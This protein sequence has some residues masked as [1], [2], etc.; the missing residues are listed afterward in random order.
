[1][2]ILVACRSGNVGKSTLARHLLA[3]R[4]G[5]AQVLPV[6]SI[7]SD[8]SDAEAIRGKQF[9]QVQELLLSV[10]SAII[11][12][13]SSNYEDFFDLMKTYA[14]SHED[15]DLFVI[16]TEPDIK[17]ERDTVNTI[18]QLAALGVPAH[19]IVVVFNKVEKPED[20]EN[21]FQLLRGYHEREAA[22]MLRRD[23]VVYSNPIYAT[24]GSRSIAE[25]RDD[26]SDYK[27]AL[28]EAIKKADQAEASKLKALIAIKRLATGVSGQLDAA[29]KAITRKTRNGE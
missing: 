12:L 7:N 24:L 3:P 5:N 22:F 6:E 19:K 29:F 23:A 27:A 28:A 8:D 26:P 18:T 10:E 11:D 21:G 15:F 20:V 25:I 14:G 2:K 17:Q 16:P 1:M 4:M 13:G 9:A